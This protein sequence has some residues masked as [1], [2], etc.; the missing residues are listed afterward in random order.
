MDGQ[1][2]RCRILYNVSKE[3]SCRRKSYVDC[4]DLSIVNNS[5]SYI[6]VRVGS[7]TY[8]KESHSCRRSSPA[9]SSK[10]NRLPKGV[11]ELEF[12]S[13]K[14]KTQH[15]GSGER[16]PSRQ[17]VKTQMWKPNN[18]AETIK[19]T[20]KLPTKPHN[21]CKKKIHRRKLGYV[22]QQVTR[23]RLV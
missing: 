14:R 19:T 17:N 12:Y 20:E 3:E 11:S 10:V 21:H 22:P 1:K 9:Q 15:Y 16:I 8:S 18:R 2:D 7:D 5:K 4:Y 13:L 6:Q 23:A